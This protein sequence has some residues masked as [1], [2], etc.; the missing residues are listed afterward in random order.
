MLRLILF[1]LF[2]IASVWL[3]IEIMRHPGFLLLFFQPWIIQVPIWF[4]AL[5]LL[6]VFVLFYL[7]IDSIEQFHFL[8]FRLK[9][10]WHIRREHRSYNKTQQG[11]SALIE[12]RWKKAENLFLSGIK[13]NLQDTPQESTVSKPLINYLGAAKAAQEQHALDR[14]DEYIQKSYQL[15]PD[16]ELAIG[17]MQA[18]L[19]IEQHQFEHAIASLNHLRQKDP[20]HPRVLNLLQ[21]AYLRL[22]DWQNLL[23]LIPSLR[24]AKIFSAE[25]QL[26]FESLVY[27]EILRA[28]RTSNI[29]ELQQIWYQIPKEVK[30]NPDVVFEYVKQLQ[31]FPETNNEIEDLIRK[32]LKNVWH[33]NLVHFY[34]TLKFSNLN[35]QLVIVGAWLKMYGQQQELLL[36]LGKLCCQVQLWGKAKD[37]FEKCLSLGP[38][39]EASLEYGKLLEQLDEPEEALQKYKQGLI[40]IPS[41]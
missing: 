27:V 23:E 9:N 29:T 3:G 36:L 10:W 38:N 31:R 2:L 11:F 33:A 28:A 14:R 1:L 22:G 6:I 13:Q 39:P 26:Q 37:Y 34:G 12:G 16:A 25:S 19:E 21:Q 18:E 7:L 4:A 30:R 24:K 20:Y 17:I 5:T 32:T 8:W 15:A 35:R 40:S 41:P